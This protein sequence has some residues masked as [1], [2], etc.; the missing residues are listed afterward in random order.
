MALKIIFMGTPDFSVPILEALHKSE[1]EIIQ[2]YTQPPKKKNRGQKI[3]VT[4]I[5]NFAYKNKLIVRSPEKL[6]AD[7][8]L[9]FLRDSKPDVIIVAAYG[10]ILPVKL[11]NMTNIKFINV[12]ASLLPKWRGAAPIQRSIMN[13]DQETGIS[14][15]KII[16]KLDAGPVMLKSK[17]S[18]SKNI[19]FEKLSN[20]LSKLGAKLILEA[21]NL[22]EKKKDNFIDQDEAEVTYAKK[23]DKKE[24][25]IDWNVKAEKVIAKINA[26]HPSPGSWFYY[27]GVRHK[28]TKA[29]EVEENGNPG[30]IINLNFTIACLHNS[31]QILE[32]QKEGKSKMK[33]AE[34]LKGNKLI[35]G[36][37]VS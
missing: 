36:S 16:P 31:I 18:I 3:S 22:I 35:K 28:V 25:K 33:V 19:N 26:L 4:P 5:H 6:D 30:E 37:N 23:I 14:I 10:K 11:L 13:L 32:L 2:V 20:L 21:I 9:K 1:H 24:S 8:E 29:I 7:H 34:Y 17:I 12:H 15:M 27:N